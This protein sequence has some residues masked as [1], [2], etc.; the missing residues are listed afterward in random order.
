[1]GITSHLFSFL[2]TVPFM[3]V[4]LVNVTNTVPFTRIVSSSETFVS[5]TSLRSIKP[6]ATR[7][8]DE[9]SSANRGKHDAEL[10]RI[11]CDLVANFCCSCVNAA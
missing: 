9:T 2:Y 6:S 8:I 11:V 7:C 3:V 1:M 4:L 5:S 10:L